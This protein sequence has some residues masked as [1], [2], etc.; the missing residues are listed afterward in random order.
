MILV[1]YCSVFLLTISIAS[2]IAVNSTAKILYI[3]SRSRYYYRVV[4]LVGVYIAALT[5]S[6]IP[7]LSEYMQIV[8]ISLI[9][10]M[11]IEL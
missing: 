7:E 2:F 11:M 8:R 9:Y 10:I 4:A 6:S 3:V 1:V 5:Y